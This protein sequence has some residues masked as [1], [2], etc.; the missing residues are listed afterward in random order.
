VDHIFFGNLWGILMNFVIFRFL[1]GT[2]S[3][4][5]VYPYRKAFIVLGTCVVTGLLFSTVVY[6]K[7][8]PVSI[9]LETLWVLGSMLGITFAHYSKKKN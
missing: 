6:G 3:P 2:M 8:I 5:P 1:V 9:Y 7:S 4:G